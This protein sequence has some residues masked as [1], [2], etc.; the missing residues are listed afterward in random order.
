MPAAQSRASATWV[1]DLIKGSGTVAPG[2]GAFAELPVTW[3]SRTAR[4]AGKTSPEELI[5]AAQASCY[6][7]AFANTLAQRGTPPTRLAVSA[8]CS[9]EVGSAGAKITTMDIDVAGQVPGLDQA[10]FARVADEAERGCPVANALR[11]NVQIKVSAK[12]EG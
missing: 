5:A 4:S 6:A 12:L 9:F 3:A 2:S 10:T 8:V 11:G 7:M 1:G